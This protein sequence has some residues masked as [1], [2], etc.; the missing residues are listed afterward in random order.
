MINNKQVNIWRG[1]IEPPTIYHVWI[2]NDLVLKLYDGTEWVVF[3]DDATVIEKI[4][5]LIDKVNDLENFM[6]N[7]TINSYKVKD[8][9]TLDAED[10]KTV[11][12]G[13]FIKQ[14]ESIASSL[15]KLDKLLDTQII[16]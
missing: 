7:A 3:L 6:N 10:L 9:P 8:N 15:L 16:E 2:E 4:N 1:D 11:S 5:Q 12:D 14:N 13:V